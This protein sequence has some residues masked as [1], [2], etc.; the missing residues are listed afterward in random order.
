MFCNE[1]TNRKPN[2][3]FYVCNEIEC[4]N[5]KDRLISLRRHY[6]AI[7]RRLHK[8][9]KLCPYCNRNFY[10]SD[11]RRISCGDD[12]C[13]E[14][15]HI[16]LELNRKSKRVHGLPKA[17]MELLGPSE[18]LY[19]PKEHKCQRC[20]TKTPNYKFCNS[21]LRAKSKSLGI[22]GNVTTGVYFEIEDL[23]GQVYRKQSDYYP[24]GK[25]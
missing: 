15:A 3:L 13:L 21:C 1:E 9:V 12:E 18:P 20:G 25:F 16:N 17:S 11:V 10:Y 7:C 5:K 8:F 2:Q 6:L 24:E 19:P 14:M 22:G 4:Q 23:I